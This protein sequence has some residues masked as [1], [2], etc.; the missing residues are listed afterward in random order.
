[1]SVNTVSKTLVL[2]KIFT[3]YKLVVIL[4][5]YAHIDFLF[6][7]TASY[8][9]KPLYEKSSSYFLLSKWPAF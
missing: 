4:H 6:N 5:Q 7:F 3:F 9:P 2:D 1:M 8:Q